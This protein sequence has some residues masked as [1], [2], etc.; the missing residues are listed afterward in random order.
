MSI[1][2]TLKKAVAG[3]HPLDKAEAAHLKAVKAGEAQE[4]SVN[5]AREGDVAASAAI[6]EGIARGANT[7]EMLSL[8]RAKREATD[9]LSIEEKRLDHCRKQVEATKKALDH[10]REKA[11]RAKADALAE[12]EAAKI[13]P[14][15]SGLA[16]SLLQTFFRLAESRE[17]IKALGSSRNPEESRF[18]DWTAEAIVSERVDDLWVTLQGGVVLTPQPRDSQIEVDKDGT[19]YLPQGPYNRQYV[20][21]RRFRVV[22]LREGVRNRYVEPLAAGISLPGLYQGA[23]PLW[24][25]EDGKGDSDLVAMRARRALERLEKQLKELRERRDNRDVV[26]RYDPIDDG[27]E[28]AAANGDIEDPAA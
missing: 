21:R 27:S 16:K 17:A 28:P 22:S 7:E 14:E 12:Q 2:S 25:P 6:E 19:S 20:R 11:N 5:Q 23:D 24:R 26:T 8:Q 18:P 13:V 10:E 4:A 1:A 15:Y 9:L 3:N